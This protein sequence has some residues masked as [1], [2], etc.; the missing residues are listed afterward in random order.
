[1][2]CKFDAPAAAVFFALFASAAVAQS[3]TTDPGDTIIA[4]LDVVD[5]D[6]RLLCL[7]AAARN[8]KT[9]RTQQVVREAAARE[10]AFGAG[11]VASKK[12][13]EREEREKD[14]VVRLE[15]GVADIIVGPL[16]NVTV[17]LDNG[18]AWRQIEGD[19]T[20]IRPP[21]DKNGLTVSV[22]KGA[23]SSYWMRIN[24]LD[25]EFRVNR[26]K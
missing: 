6:E 4:C 21:R 2:R 20:V 1:M 14:E 24:E 18:Q 25:R 10:D 12:R 9:T 3:T 16:K 19:R 7:E 11:T 15:A 8:L 13:A 5:S 17:V 23:L 26:V 22:T